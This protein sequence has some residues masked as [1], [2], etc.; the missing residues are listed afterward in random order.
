MFSHEERV[1]AIQLFLK[2]DCSYAATIRELGYPSVGALRKW[3]NEYLI[4]GALHL[5]HR[6]KSKY[7]E[8]QKRVAVNHYFEYGQCYARTIRLLGYPNRESLRHWCEELAPGAR[9]LRKSAVKLTQ[10]QKDN[11]LK[12]FYA[13]QANRKSLAEAEGISRV[14]LYQ[15]KDMYL[16]RGFPLRM[17]Q[18]NQEEQKELLL[19][20]VKELQ[21]QVHQLQLE[22]ALLEGATELLKKEEGINLL[23]LTNQEKTRLIDALRNQFKLNELL[24]QLHLSKSSYFYQKHVIDKPDKY[25]EERQLIV[26]I[27]NSNF[28]SY[29]YRRIHQELK[30]MGK[31]LSEKV[32]RMLMIEENL[33]VTFSKRKKY[34]SY[35]GEISTAQPNLLNRNFKATRPNEKWLTDITEF[36]IPAGKVYLS[37]IVDCYDGAIISWTIGTKPDAALVN[38]MLDIGLATLQNQERPIVHSDRGAHYRWPGWIERMNKANLPRSMSKKGCSPDN[39]ACEGFFGRLKNEMF[40]QRDWKNTSMNQFMDHLDDYI[41]WYNN[42]RI[43]LSLGGLSPLQYRKKQ[44]CNC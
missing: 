14:T 36:K 34:S 9:K 7:S 6:K 37:P 4:S 40:Y 17:T 31:I 5:E 21:K 25:A 20:E 23:Q 32:V 16:G 10:D 29:G 43:K 26:T 11:V 42:H 18:E 35:A 28:C 22:K 13:P 27:F 38:T 39:S 41:Q 30:N 33:I 3:Y 44:E 15:W 12:K 2:Y 19:T 1:K 8:E 24:Q